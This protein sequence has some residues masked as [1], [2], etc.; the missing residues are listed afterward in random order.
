VSASIC[1]I[2][3]PAFEAAHGADAARVVQIYV[4]EIVVGEAALQKHL[5]EDGCKAEVDGLAGADGNSE[6]ET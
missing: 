4:L 5:P 6:K 1:I 2:A 3:S